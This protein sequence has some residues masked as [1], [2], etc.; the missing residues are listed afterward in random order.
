MALDG[1]VLTLCMGVVVM[2]RYL[3]GGSF[4]PTQYFFSLSWTPGLYLALAV[5]SK[6]YLPLQTPPE[7]IKRQSWAISLFFLVIASFFFLTHEATAYSRSIFLVSW[8]GCLLVMPLARS[9]AG[10]MAPAIFCWRTPCVL[11]GTA[12]QVHMMAKHLDH[13]QSNLWVAAVSVPPEDADGFDMPNMS[14]DELATFATT[15]PQCFAVLLINPSSTWP[16]ANA[17]ETLSLYFRNVLLQSPTIDQIST[18]TR[19]VSLDDMTVLT[20][21]FKLLDPWRM[22]FKR[23][24]DVT[25]CLTV[26]FVIFP[27]LCLLYICIRLDSRGPAFFTQERLGKDGKPFR[28]IKFRTMRID[29]EEYLNCLLQKNSE[30][31]CQW[32][33]N[34]KLVNDPR[35]TKVG[36]W[37]RKTSIDELPQLLN[38]LMGSMSLVGP[39]PIVRSEIAKYEDHYSTYKR[40]RPGLTGLWQ[41]SGRSNTDY[42]KRVALDVAYVRNWSI[43]L[44]LFILA[45]T[46]GEV[47][48]LTGC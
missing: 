1:C 24:F 15:N 8:G 46:V 2:G 30:L 16:P 41:V 42:A 12:S 18:W 11:I 35:I 17:M 29:A 27:F 21:Q 28:I 32:R 38:V 10:K 20:C 4:T 22:R 44:D 5:L 25:F 31:A 6:V 9:L 3:L 19:G 33:E 37:L 34:Q 47:I 36:F 40:V 23:V 26:G 7:I 13:P 14:L 45:R 39:R 43:Y 48:C